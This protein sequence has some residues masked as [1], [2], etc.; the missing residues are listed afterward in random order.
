MGSVALAVGTTRVDL[1]LSE[2]QQQ[3]G[4]AQRLAYWSEFSL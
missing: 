3:R 4:V 1:L 2:W